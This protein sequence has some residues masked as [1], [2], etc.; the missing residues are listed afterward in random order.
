MRD[1]PMLCGLVRAGLIEARA[2]GQNDAF[3]S[4]GNRQ[5]PGDPVRRQERRDRNVEDRNF[6]LESDPRGQF[7]QHSAKAAR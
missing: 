7:V 1:S 4:R 2:Y 3:D 6:G 5:V